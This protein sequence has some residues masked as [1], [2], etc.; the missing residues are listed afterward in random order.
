MNGI[1]V[2]LS[3]TAVGLWLAEQ[4]VSGIRVED[5]LTL[6]FAAIGLGI[7]NAVVRPIAVILTI[8][9]TVLSLGLFLWVIN[10]GMLSL[11]SAF[12][13]GFE[14]A[15]FGSALIGAAIVSLTGW[16]GNAFVGDAGRFEVVRV[17]RGAR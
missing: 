13:A 10:A 6:V 11:T 1:L 8:P 5:T 3:I 9:I 17:E 16:I 4:L 12:V 15:S 7:I 2:R 14:V